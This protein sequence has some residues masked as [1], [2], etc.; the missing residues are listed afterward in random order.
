MDV[1]EGSADENGGFAVFDGSEDEEWTI[2]YSGTSMYFIE[3]P[4]LKYLEGYKTLKCNEL[5][6][7]NNTY[8]WGTITDNDYVICVTIEPGNSVRLAVVVKAT[9]SNLST[10]KTW[11]S[12]HPLQ[13][14]YELATP[15]T[16]SF[17][18]TDVELLEGTN[19]VSTNGE[20]VA[21]T[22]G[23]SLWQ[24]IDKLKTDTEGKLDKSNVADVEGDTASKAYSVN[25]FM[26]RAD[27]LY[28]V[29]APIASGASITASNTTKTTIGAVL[30]A[31]LNA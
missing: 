12:N 13:V 15:T 5:S 25:D 3:L 24:D 10:F 23:R 8:A 19:V 14:C 22:Y 1:T 7:I 17:T 2:G 6:V 20:K 21:V 28:K 29:T 31:L 9:E 30:T 16:I 26:L 18:P 27:G 11:L 4:N